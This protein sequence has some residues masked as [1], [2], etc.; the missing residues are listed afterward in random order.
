M[1]VGSVTSS[2]NVYQPTSSQSPFAAAKKNFKALEDA[3]KSGDLK[4]AQSA[5]AE[6]QKNAPK[7]PS[8]TASTSTS[9][10]QDP[11]SALASALQSGDLNAAKSAFQSIQDMFKSHNQHKKHDKDQGV[12]GV[13]ATQGTQSSQ[14]ISASSLA[15]MTNGLF[16]QSSTDNSSSGSDLMAMFQKLGSKLDL[17]V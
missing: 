2:S 14:S 9:D 11:F 8:Q 6:I 17:K 10:S 1:S 15:A 7:K 3:L 4:A 13:G 12:A 5:F 16:S